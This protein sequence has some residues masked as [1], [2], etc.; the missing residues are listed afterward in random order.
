MVQIAAGTTAENPLPFSPCDLQT[1]DQ[2]TIGAEKT[3][4]SENNIRRKWTSWLSCSL[5][6]N[7]KVCALRV[8]YVLWA[9]D[10]TQHLSIRRKCHRRNTHY[11][12]EAELG[13][14]KNGCNVFQFW[15]K[16]FCCCPQIPAKEVKKFNLFSCGLFRAKINLEQC[17]LQ[18]YN[19]ALCS[20]QFYMCCSDLVSSSYSD[21]S[22]F[23]VWQFT[24]IRMFLAWKT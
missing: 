5:E 23:K 14:K 17:Y 16:D 18:F 19:T 24:M 4:T 22:L 7:S 12:H 8:I 2:L 11:W 15:S 10:C 20:I 13:W 3:G 9:T 21:W 1:L 6:W